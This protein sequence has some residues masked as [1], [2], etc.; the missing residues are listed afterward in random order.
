MLF[1]KPHE[2]LERMN[3][4]GIAAVV[5]AGAIG[6]P[7]IGNPIYRDNEAL[8]VLKERFI[9]A[10]GSGDLY[11][12][13]RTGG[14]AIYT[15]VTNDIRANAFARLAEQRFAGVMSPVVV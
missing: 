3:K 5:S 11:Q 15:D 10:S 8:Q 14:T 6:S 12:A 9:P 13:E 1:M 2:L 4:N 7:Q